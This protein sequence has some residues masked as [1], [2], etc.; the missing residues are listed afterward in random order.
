[1]LNLGQI[2]KKDFRILLTDFTHHFG[3]TLFIIVICSTT[4]YF[5]VTLKLSSQVSNTINQKIARLPSQQMINLVPPDPNL[6]MYTESSSPYDNRT[7]EGATASANVI[8]HGPRDKKRIAL[9]FD[10]EMTD[11]MRAGLVSGKVP[12]SYDKRIVDILDQTQTK[13]TFFLTG[14]WIEL[15]PNI[16]KQL[17]ND[18]L[19]ELGSHSYTDSSYQ[20]FCYGLGKLANTIKIE[21]IGA[22]EKLLREHAG[23]DNQLFRFPGG[24]Y[25]PDDVKLVNQVGD[26]VVHWDVVGSDGFNVNAKQ[27]ANNILDKTQNGSIIILHLNGP[28]NAPKTA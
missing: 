6:D 14:S 2:F 27:I 7:L 13:A 22:T 15:Y 18:P 28:P 26:T 17:A 11:G 1:M 3:Y 24:C 21:D 20:G 23:I 8:F 5:L 25:A 9:T 10:A 19:F 16:A 12:S 4:V